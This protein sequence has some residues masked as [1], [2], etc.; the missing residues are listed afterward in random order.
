MTGLIPVALAVQ[1][2]LL[3]K[4]PSLDHSLCLTWAP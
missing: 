4:R 1:E 2:L 3:A